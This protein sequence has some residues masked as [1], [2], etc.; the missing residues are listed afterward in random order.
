MSTPLHFVW[1]DQE[2]ATTGPMDHPDR[3]SLRSACGVLP[4][5]SECV[6]TL[7]EWLT[8]YFSGQPHCYACTADVKRRTGALTQADA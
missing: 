1:L 3:A 2:F 7:Q 8:T 5:V 6:F 4:P